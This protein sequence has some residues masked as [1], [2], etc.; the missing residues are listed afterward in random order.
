MFT[1]IIYF[2]NVFR[3]PAAQI[4]IHNNNSTKQQMTN[5]NR[6]SRINK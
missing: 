2:F 3:K 5:K 6:S 4:L 1:L